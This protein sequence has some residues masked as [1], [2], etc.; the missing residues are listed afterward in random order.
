MCYAYNEKGEKRKKKKME[1]IDFP[2]KKM[3]RS[4]EGKENNS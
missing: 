3:I 4:L 1:G 2:N